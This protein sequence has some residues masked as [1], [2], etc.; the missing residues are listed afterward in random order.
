MDIYEYLISRRTTFS[1]LGGESCQVCQKI[2]SDKYIFTH[3]C[4]YINIY[5]YAAT[6]RNTQGNT[7]THCK[8]LQHPA[9]HRNILR[10]TA[11][12]C[13]TYEST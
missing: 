4:I 11:T 10:N 12:H 5:T 6:H 7:A 9:T 8:D 3:V 13:N 1:A 2:V